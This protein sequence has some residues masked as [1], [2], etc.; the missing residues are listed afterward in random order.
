MAYAGKWPHIVQGP[1]H[2]ALEPCNGT[3][4]KEAAVDPVKIDDVWAELVDNGTVGARK[5]VKGTGNG[6]S[7]RIK[8]SQGLLVQ[9]GSEAWDGRSIPIAARQDNVWV[10]IEFLLHQHAG[11]DSDTVESPKEPGGGDGSAADPVIGVED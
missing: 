4:G 11:I 8:G 1:H 9:H 7:L 5:P 10:L 6:G 2:R 3:D